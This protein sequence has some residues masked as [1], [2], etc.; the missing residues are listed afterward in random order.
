MIENDMQIY[1]GYR[2]YC[3]NRQKLSKIPSKRTKTFK[4]AKPSLKLTETKDFL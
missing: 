3:P 4:Y 1:K 2:K